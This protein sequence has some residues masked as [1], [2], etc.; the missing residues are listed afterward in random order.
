MYQLG[1]D[2]PSQPFN[3]P[4]PSS[5]CDPGSLVLFLYSYYFIYIIDVTIAVTCYYC[6]WQLSAA[7][8][9]GSPGGS[10]S[11]T[12]QKKTLF[13]SCSNLGKVA[14]QYA[15]KLGIRFIP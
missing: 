14:S 6:S 15:R 4:S 7:G 9:G 8:H 1:A 13:A 3:V 2:R 10:T 5:P 11:A 12:C